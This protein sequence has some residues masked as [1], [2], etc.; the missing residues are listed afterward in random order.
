[1]KQSAQQALTQQV[2]AGGTTPWPSTP[3]TWHSGAVTAA[4]PYLADKDPQHVP[5]VV[6][7]G[8]VI[9]IAFLWIAVRSMFG[10]KKK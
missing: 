2:S 1:L 9:G 10:K 4:L 5:G 3:P 8:V 7:T 6:I